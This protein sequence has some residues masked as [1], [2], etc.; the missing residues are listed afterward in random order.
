MFRT[1]KDVCITDVIK[2]E[3]NS[4]TLD[5]DAINRRQEKLKQEISMGSV[6]KDWVSELPWKEQTALISAIR[7]HDS[8]SEELTKPLVKFVRYV[9]L[10]NAD[11]KTNFMVNDLPKVEVAKELIKQ[12]IALDELGVISEHWMHHY[13]NACKVITRGHPVVEVRNYFFIMLSP[14]FVKGK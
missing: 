2:R 5:Y 3:G 11:K 1:Y 12:L 6:L 7:G 4:V 8:G 9:V 13:V 14:L 10:N